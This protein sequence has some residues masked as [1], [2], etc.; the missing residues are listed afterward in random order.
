MVSIQNDVQ[1]FKLMSIQLEAKHES[2]SLWLQSLQQMVKI[3]KDDFFEHAE[4]FGQ[5]WETLL[6][7]L[8]MQTR[9]NIQDEMDKQTLSLV[10]IKESKGCGGVAQLDANCLSCG[11]LNVSERNHIYA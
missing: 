1:K 8:V 11:Q 2:N 10:G 9:L 7:F 3:V 5:R 6:E 4:K